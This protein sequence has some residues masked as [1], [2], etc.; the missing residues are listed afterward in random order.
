M[1]PPVSIRIRVDRAEK[2]L[3]RLEAVPTS[4]KGKSANRAMSEPL[5]I[6][7]EENTVPN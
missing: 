3:R 7:P 1:Y 2:V 5:Q 6:I 4:Q